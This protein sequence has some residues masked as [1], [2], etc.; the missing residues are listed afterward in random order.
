MSRRHGGRTHRTAAHAG[1][2]AMPA[3]GVGLPPQLVSTEPIAPA[4]LPILD[5]APLVASA[6]IDPERSPGPGLSEFGTNGSP[7]AGTGF[8]RAANGNGHEQDRSAAVGSVPPSSP[9]AAQGCTAAQLRR[10]IKSRSYVP[11]HE[12]RRRFGIDGVEDDVTPVTVAAGLV[13]VGLPPREGTLLGE[14]FRA[15]DIGYELSVDPCTPIVIGVY[16]MR[17]VARG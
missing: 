13:F 1:Q 4:G 16:P 6:R 15:G 12:L 7:V 3:S 2:K 11:M 8:A 10:F 9:P 17:P 5:P 14:L